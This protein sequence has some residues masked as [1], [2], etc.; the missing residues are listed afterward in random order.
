MEPKELLELFL[1]PAKKPNSNTQEVQEVSRPATEIPILPK[2]ETMSLKEKK[3]KEMLDSLRTQGN[4]DGVKAQRINMAFTP[5]NINFIRIMSAIYGM[6][7]TQYVN[8]LID[9]ERLHESGTYER[10]KELLKSL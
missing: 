6:T 7:M 5:A 1:N 2:R 9:D 10:V 8:S 3:R 4:K